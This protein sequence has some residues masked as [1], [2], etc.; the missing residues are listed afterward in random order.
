MT[1]ILGMLLLCCPLILWAVDY[2][3]MQIEKRI[4][5]YGQVRVEGEASVTK[6]EPEK[7]KTAGKEAA[8]ELPLS[9]ET[10]YTRYCAA[11]HRTGLAGAPIFR[12]AE[13]WKSRLDK[14]SLE[15]LTATAV[16]GINAMPA[17]G[18]CNQC[19]EEDIRRSIEYMLPQ[20]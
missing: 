13:Q 15:E 9:A 17:K 12:N 19:S 6:T 1:R 18:T 20:S 3:R 2:D 7:Q 4:K 5:P 14:K 8:E 16:K 11:C 10:I